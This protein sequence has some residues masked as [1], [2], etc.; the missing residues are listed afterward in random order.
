MSSADAS[1]TVRDRRA[2]PE[3]GSALRIL[4]AAALLGGLTVGLF[5]RL[6]MHLLIRL[7]ADADGVTS[8]DGFE[9]GRFTV[10][11]SLNLLLVGV[12]L[13]LVSGVLY[14]L[15]Q[16]LCFGP[17]WFRTLSLAVGAGTVAATQVV[18]A[19]GVDF[20]LLGPL[21]LAVGIFVALPMLQVALLDLWAR[22]IRRGRGTA[23][24]R[25]GGALAWV[26]RGLLVVW[27]V[28]AVA[29]LVGDVHTL[30][31]AAG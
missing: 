20:R 31:A 8:D 18:H 27:F 6:G 29:S 23:E 22:R 17:D 28:L 11:G 16:P 24:P 10:G 26:L 4:G 3:A 19:D 15:L 7:N 14:L 5:S 2:G 30:A 25:L 12:G 9:M 21:A 1:T 13:G